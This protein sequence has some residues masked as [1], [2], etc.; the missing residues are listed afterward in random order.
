MDRL[1]GEIMN[2]QSLNNVNPKLND[3]SSAVKSKLKSL[4]EIK[5]KLIY[6]QALKQSDELSGQQDVA[7]SIGEMAEFSLNH[8]MY[9]SLSPQQIKM[10]KSSLQKY[11]G[12]CSH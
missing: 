4:G 9:D 10:L 7:E 1:V 5:A 2:Y 8:N 12:R 3:F 11:R 6:Q